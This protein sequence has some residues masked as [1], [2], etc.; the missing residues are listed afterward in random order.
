LKRLEL[1]RPF[2]FD[3]AGSKG[4]ACVGPQDDGRQMVCLSSGPELALRVLE[5][6]ELLDAPL[7]SLPAMH[8]T[9]DGDSLSFQLFHAVGHK[10]AK[11][12]IGLHSQIQIVKGDF[13]SFSGSAGTAIC[14]W[15]LAAG[16]WR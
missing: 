6:D 11:Y 2:D 4:G 14:R 15:P 12:N 10:G 9:H 3:R 16:R 13:V 7:R 8:V 5:Q 1:E